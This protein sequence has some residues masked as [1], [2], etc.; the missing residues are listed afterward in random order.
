[1]EILLIV[2]AYLYVLDTVWYS[3]QRSAVQMHFELPW[4]PKRLTDRRQNRPWAE[5]ASTDSTGLLHPG[6][7]AHTPHPGGCLLFP[8]SQNKA[9]RPPP[10]TT[11]QRACPTPRNSAA[12]TA[13][14]PPHTHTWTGPY[15]S[16]HTVMFWVPKVQQLSL[17]TQCI[18][19]ERILTTNRLFFIY[20]FTVIC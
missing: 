6:T 3:L 12:S 10:Q 18:W 11:L 4:H 15:I 1:M 5:R 20:F 17:H 19:Q 8:W 13:P 14:I 9:R 2:F 16:L 7:H